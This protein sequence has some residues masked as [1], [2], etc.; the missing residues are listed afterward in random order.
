M[1]DAIQERIADQ[2][3]ELLR[4]LGEMP[5]KPAPHASGVPKQASL[6]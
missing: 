5:V 1:Y 6:L 4:Q 2:D 3:K